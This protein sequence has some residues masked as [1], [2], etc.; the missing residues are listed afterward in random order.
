[1]A[2][3]PSD[4]KTDPKNRPST[5]R[6]DVARRAGVSSAT[7]SRVFN[8]P[9][10]VS[11]AKQTAVRLAAEELRYQPDQNAASLRRGRPGAVH[12][13]EI[14]RPAETTWA[15]MRG[16]NWFYGDI[17]RGIQNALASTGYSLQLTTVTTLD[18][19]EILADSRTCAGIIAFDIE[20]P[21]EARRL[22]ALGIP[23]VL[24]HHGTGLEDFPRVCTSNFEGGRLAGHLLRETG[25]RSPLYITDRADTI[26]VHR[27]RLEGFLS[28]W[29]TDPPDQA[30]RVLDI[31]EKH[32]YTRLKEALLRG[33]HD[34][35]AFV[36]D[37]AALEI[38]RPLL[39]ETGL[40]IPRDF[41]AVAYDHLPDTR[42][43]PFDLATVELNL[44]EIY[45]QTAEMLITQEIPA[46]SASLSPG[47]QPRHRVVPPQLIRGTSILR[48][49]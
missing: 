33:K 49:T 16:Y 23:F 46:P 36:N 27:R 37:F 40:S 7:V 35:L 45:R 20:D 44:G 9:E 14:R 19:L 34:A 12:F 28:P 41:S 4:P 29:E 43:F 3:S 26:P 30:P 5:N 31:R 39:A 8:H 48:R 10:L 32:A 21:L 13:V 47:S 38:L 17:I 1:M 15:Q 11:P 24:G 2:K 6:N 18:E 22:E 42:A 25:H